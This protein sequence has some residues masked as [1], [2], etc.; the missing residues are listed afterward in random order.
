MG[1]CVLRPRTWPVPAR[2]PRVILDLENRFSAKTF[3]VIW[4]RTCF[5][6]SVLRAGEPVMFTNVKLLVAIGELI[7]RFRILSQPAILNLLFI[8]SKHYPI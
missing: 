6:A 1:M 4:P 8:E 2:R 7:C 3:L 5:E